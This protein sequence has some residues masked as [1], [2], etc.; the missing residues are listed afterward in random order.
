MKYI[1]NIYKV[2]QISSEYT[3]VSMNLQV[4]MNSIS[5]GQMEY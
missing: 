1:A 5:S 2:L 4:I 3:K